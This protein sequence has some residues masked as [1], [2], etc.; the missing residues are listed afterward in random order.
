MIHTPIQL[1]VKKRKRQTEQSLQVQHEVKFRDMTIYLVERKMGSSRRTFL[2]NLAR[3]K[4]FYVQ[5]DLS[6]EVTH[7]VAEDNEAQELR[8][9]LLDHGLK[10]KASVQ[11]LDITWFTESMAAGRPVV[12]ESRHRIQGN[13]DQEI[14]CLQRSSQK[15]S[16]YACQRRT[17]IINCNKTFTDAFEVLAEH[18]EFNENAGRCLAFMRA[19]S[20]LKSLSG[21]VGCFGDLE[22]LPCLG[23]Q[24]KAVI[25]DILETGRSFKVQEILND[26]KF[27]VLKLFTSV[28]G[29]GPKTSEK[30]YRKGLRT[31]E[32]VHAD[33]SITLNK[34]QEAGFRYYD[35][36][37]KGI[38]KAEAEALA[39]IIEEAVHMIVPDATVTLTGGF[40][41]GKE[42]GHDVDFI[43]TTP[44][45]G[46]EEGLLVGVIKKLRI[47]GLLLYHELH[48]ATFD[49]TKLPSRK[50]EA[51][52]HYPKCFLILKLWSKLL[53]DSAQADGASQRD[54]RAVRVDLVAPPISH[55][56]FAL[57]GWTGSRQ[58]ERDMR[59]FA[60]HER[61]MLLDNHAL[62]DKTKQIFLLAKTEEDIFAHLGLEYI[63]PWERN[64]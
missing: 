31:F 52:D 21:A 11:L 24:T 58:F 12:V 49:V 5:Y 59:R 4:G 14:N 60:Q 15:V 64:A 61:K 36:I 44:E 9:W 6:N 26:E 7:V 63:E 45:S 19:T 41:R 43:L 53:D 48:P 29:I 8:A 38:S 28:F 2:T 40:R 16:Q 13:K 1:Q 47:K 33:N 51:M 55:F 23:D 39:G 22:G 56:A 54:W 10:D 62:Y 25:E 57:L 27:Q 30:W 35:D 17:T 20:V 34:R 50:F 46:E 42:F 3:K 37:L 18:A 32:E